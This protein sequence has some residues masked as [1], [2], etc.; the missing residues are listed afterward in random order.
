MRKFNF[1]TS[2]FYNAF[3]L[4]VDYTPHVVMLTDIKASPYTILDI[5]T[6]CVQ[7]AGRFRNG[8]ST[9][10]HIYTTDNNLPIMTTE[11]IRIHQF[12]Q[13]HAYNTIRT[14]YNDCSIRNRKECFRRSHAFT[15]IQQDALSRWKEKLFC[16]WQWYQWQAG[17]R[18]LPWRW[19][20]HISILCLLHVPPI[21]YRIYLS[22]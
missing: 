1:F 8:L 6:D 3:D 12:A 13:E 22:V 16:H 11:E 7:I 17:N 20:N 4:E 14:L 19:Q 15:S 9:L 21:L 2:R 10:T 5:N 18:Q